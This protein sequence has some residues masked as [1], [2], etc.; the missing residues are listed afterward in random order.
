[1]NTSIV[2]HSGIV[3]DPFCPKPEQIVIIDIAHALS[4]MCRFAGHCD[5]FYSV[6]Q[7]A[8]GV[9]VY[10]SKEN[11]L[12]GLLHDASEAYMVD[13][14]TPLKR[15]PVFEGYRKAETAFMKCVSDAFG[16]PWPIPLEVCEIDNRILFT[17]AASLGFDVSL[18][19]GF[20]TPGLPINIRP[21]SPE[22]AKE[23][24]LD[25]YDAITYTTNNMF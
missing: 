16:L 2:T 19:G 17:E 1:M 21:Q 4:N 9:S 8:V 3:I 14:P 24:F 18:F 7:H 23:A 13:I 5:K 25:W 20:G 12:W 11:A 22:R 6:A 15:S 10:C